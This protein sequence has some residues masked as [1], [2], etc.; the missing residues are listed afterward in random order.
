LAWPVQHGKQSMLQT[1]SGQH[2][3][4]GRMGGVHHDGG[5]VPA[6]SRGIMAMTRDGLVKA[7]AVVRLSRLELKHTVAKQ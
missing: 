5:R 7:V 3:L 4:L 6:T 2:G 1:L